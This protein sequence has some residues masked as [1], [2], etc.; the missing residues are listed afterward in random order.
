MT[1]AQ[2]IKA[3]HSV[4]SYTGQKIEGDVHTQLRQAVDE[5][6]KQSGLHIQLCIN[7]PNAFS[8]TM[9][10]Y[11]KFLN[12]NN[13]IALVG[14]K[15]PDLDEKCGNYGEK[16]VL[17]A[18][19]LGLNTCWVAMTYS[20]G[21]S[22]AAVDAG[23]KLL[24]VIALG[25]GV[26]DGVSHKV[27]PIEELSKTNG[28]APDWFRSGMAAA[29]LAPTAINQQKFTLA[30]NGNTVSAAAGLG[31]YSKVDLGIVKYHFEVGAGNT[32]WQWA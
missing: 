28:A 2:A 21:K 3:R 9:A 5:C 4:R 24:I 14:K 17:E 26:N 27:K 19:R 18:Q 29:Q 11:G 1:Y 10:R 31:F 20:K 13:Y 32:G 23:E 15:G 6:N 25:Y 12:V 8:G 30:L 7:E 16:I 22:T